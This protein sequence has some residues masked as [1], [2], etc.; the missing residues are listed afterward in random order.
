[1]FIRKVGIYLEVYS[2]KTQNNNIVIQIEGLY[3]I[4]RALHFPALSL[5]TLRNV[6]I[7]LQIQTAPKPRISTT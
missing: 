5:Q 7:V 4:W 2:V 1:M 3:R 6:G